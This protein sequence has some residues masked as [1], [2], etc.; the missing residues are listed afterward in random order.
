MGFSASDVTKF[1]LLLWLL[2]LLLQAIDTT[3]VVKEGKGIGS[4][5]NSMRAPS[6]TPEASAWEERPRDNTTKKPNLSKTRVGQPLH[7]ADSC[8]AE[9]TQDLVRGM[10]SGGV[11]KWKGIDHLFP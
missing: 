11:S 1:C 6:I 9:T 2:S 7:D 3:H 8:V 4:G 5:T 10:G